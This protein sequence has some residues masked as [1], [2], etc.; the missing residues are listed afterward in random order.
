[1]IP[2]ELQPEPE[3]FLRRVKKDGR[4][5]LLA[6]PHPISKEW[7]GKEYWQRA[8]PDM[9]QA[10]KRICAYCCHWIPHSTGNHSI[11]HF[12]PKSQQPS[13]AYDWAN[14]RYVSSRFNSRKGT[15]IILDPFNLLNESFAIDFKSFLIHPNSNLSPT[16]QAN[17]CETIKYLQLNSD[18]DLVLERQTYFLE[19]QAGEISFEHLEKKAPFIAYEILRQEKKTRSKI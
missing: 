4:E 11:D 8:L 3:D 18:D 19:Y 6:N 5:F 15:K 14:F 13:L 2:V 1:M 17:V 16:G 10:Y 12:I 9:R 7:K